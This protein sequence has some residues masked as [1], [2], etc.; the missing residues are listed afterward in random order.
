M[1]SLAAIAS[2]AITLAVAA[3]PCAMEG[4][5]GGSHGGGS[6]ARGGFSAGA[7]FS[8]TPSYHYSGG[9]LAGSRAMSYAAP[10]ARPN[11][12]GRR[13]VA[14][15]VIRY[16]YPA[17]NA[18]G[19]PYGYY[20]LNGYAGTGYP[21]YY[22][23]PAPYYDATVAQPPVPDYGPPPQDQSQ[24]Q[25]PEDAPR[26]SVLP[27]TQ[28][29]PAAEDAITLIFKD[30]RPPQQIHN[31]I[32]SRTM[33]Y[34]RDQHHQDIPVDQLDLTATQK[35]NQNSSVDFQLPVATNLTTN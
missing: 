29:P 11:F 3:L 32:L 25:A 16:R 13:P 27:R 12:Y 33:L 8:A 34:V 18:V 4:Q 15:P 10:L 30:G 22:P 19:V 9:L 1:K 31:Y 35:A 23:D 5:R 2:V 26:Y 14:G 24:P 21:G 17:R 20:G 7:H 6:G 28:P